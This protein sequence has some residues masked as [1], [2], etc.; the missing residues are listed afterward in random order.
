MGWRLGRSGSRVGLI[1]AHY[2]RERVAFVLLAILTGVCGACHRVTFAAKGVGCK[3]QGELAQKAGSKLVDLEDELGLG[4]PVAV[5]LPRDSDPMWWFRYRRGGMVIELAANREITSQDCY[6]DMWQRDSYRYIGLCWMSDRATSGGHRRD[7]D[8][9]L[10]RTCEIGDSS[11]RLDPR[12]NV[13]EALCAIDM[14][15][16]HALVAI[17]QMLHLSGPRRAERASFA[18]PMYTFYYDLADDTMLWLCAYSDRD[19]ADID[20]GASDGRDTFWFNGYWSVRRTNR[21]HDADGP[22]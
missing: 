7:S 6:L 9:R 10:S 11:E 1:E 21:I 19:D 2:V 17:E 8:G 20:L 5:D 4:D 14:T 22:R 16:P 3:L 15:M 13:E 18:N 12:T